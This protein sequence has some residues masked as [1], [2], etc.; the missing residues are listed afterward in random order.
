MGNPWLPAPGIVMDR[1]GYLAPNKRKQ[2]NID[3]SLAGP[4]P[5]P[6]T[7]APGS[8]SAPFQRPRTRAQRGWWAFTAREPGLLVTRRLHHPPAAP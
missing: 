3:A 1:G 4:R 7:G 8:F 5:H 2:A 6:I